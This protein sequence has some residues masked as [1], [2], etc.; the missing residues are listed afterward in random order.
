MDGLRVKVRVVVGEPITFGDVIEMAEH[1]GWTDRELYR[2][3]A[4]KIGIK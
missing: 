3:I 1:I 2:A 4:H